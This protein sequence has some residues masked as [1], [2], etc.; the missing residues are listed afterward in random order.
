[1]GRLPG[2]T[3]FAIREKRSCD[4]LERTRCMKYSKCPF[5]KS[6][7]QYEADIKKVYARLRSLD[8]EQQRAISARYYAGERPWKST[9]TN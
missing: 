6:R 2:N 5:Y 3:C 4:A 8:E 1:M 9:I 7:T